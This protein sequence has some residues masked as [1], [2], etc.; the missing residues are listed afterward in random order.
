MGVT[1]T[2]KENREKDR[3]VALRSH[4]GS[5]ITKVE[6]TLSTNAR[7]FYV[8]TGD[9]DVSSEDRKVEGMTEATPS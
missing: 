6:N 3:E 9:F 7:R 4:G 5:L 8:P 2:T 1:T